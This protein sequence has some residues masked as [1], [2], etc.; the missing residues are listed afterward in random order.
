MATGKVD[1]ALVDDILQKQQVHREA[2]NDL[3]GVPNVP[4]VTK[5]KKDFPDCLVQLPDSADKM[6]LLKALP[7]L[8]SRLSRWKKDYNQL[9]PTSEDAQKIQ[10]Y[11][12]LANTLIARYE[13]LINA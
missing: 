11:I 9:I 10:K 12:T 8:R 6:Q 4:K 7:N 5:A 3:N 2:K 1:K 13:R